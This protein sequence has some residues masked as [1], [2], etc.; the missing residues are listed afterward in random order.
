MNDLPDRDQKTQASERT[1]EAA[2]WFALLLDESTPPEDY[3]RFRAWLL[4]DER[5]AQA[6]ARIEKLW[7]GAALEP[8][9]TEEAPSRR[10]VLKM[11]SGIILLAGVGGAAWTLST[12]PDFQTGIGEMRSLTL[13][14]GSH[15]ELGAASA[16][17]IDFT[18]SLR[19]IVLHGG[20]AYFTVAPDSARPFRVEAGS[21][22]ATALGTAYSVAIAPG[23]TTVAVTEHHVRVEGG[24]RTVDLQQG[25]AIDWEGGTLGVI[26]KGDA[27]NHVRWRDR[28]LI[29][30]AR[31]LGEIIAEVNRWRKGR[32]VIIDRALAARRVTAILDVNDIDDIDTTLQQG[33]PVSLQNYTSVLTIVTARK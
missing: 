29:F 7:S 14:D 18:K 21:V 32:L 15:V 1:H 6:Y 12:R 24:G 11:T 26:T 10:S 8:V 9:T 31:P 25:D 22:T 5:N 27:D 13:S 20:E 3:E 33:L 30:L 23:R 4:S 2:N 19:R 16:I 17:S 28:Q